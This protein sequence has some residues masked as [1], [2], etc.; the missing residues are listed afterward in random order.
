MNLP[1]RDRNNVNHYTPKS[2]YAASKVATEN[3]GSVYSKMYNLTMVGLR[4]FTVYGSYGRPDMA[5]WSFVERLVTG[6]VSNKI[7]LYNHGKMQR[8]FT[9]WTDIV[10]GIQLAMDHA[11]RQNSHKIEDHNGGSNEVFNLGKGNVRSLYEFV[12]IILRTL[13]L[14]EDIDTN[15]MIELA[16]TP[17]GEVLFT[18]ADLTKSN[19]VLGYRPE[20]ELEVGIPE[21]VDWYLKEWKIKA[22]V[23]KQYLLV[24]ALH[25]SDSK[26]VEGQYR[27]I[28]RWYDS[29]KAVTNISDLS[30]SP[31]DMVIVHDGLD[32][33]IFRS[34]SDIVFVNMG[35]VRFCAM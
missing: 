3:M 10:D 18:S 23:R 8:D 17:G 14:S 19:M 13:G 5:L 4:F 2:V 32:P 28:K 16:D 9:H 33:V 1:L 25:S 11:L 6:N 35:Q 20:T 27:I 31:V 22:D 34:F 15:P 7:K 24:S 12:Q 21:F 29:F 30:V 26:G